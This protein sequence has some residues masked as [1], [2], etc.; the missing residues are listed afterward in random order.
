MT[1]WLDD[2][3]I[4]AWYEFAAS[5]SWRRP[6]HYSDF[7]ITT[8]LDIERLFKFS[9]RAAQNFMDIVFTFSCVVRSLIYSTKDSHP[10]KTGI[11]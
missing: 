11:C 2:N 1:F 4:K 8:I 7:A 6:Q 10:F 3:A 5:L 9:L